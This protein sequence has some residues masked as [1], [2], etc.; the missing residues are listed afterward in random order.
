MTKKHADEDGI[1]IKITENG[2]YLVYGKP[3]LKQEFITPNEEGASWEYQDG[4]RFSTDGEEPIALCRCGH[5]K[6]APFCDESHV[7]CGFDGTETASLEPIAEGSKEYRGPNYTL[8]DNE[9]YCAF[10]RFCDAFGQVWN[11]VMDGRDE[12]D[13]LAVREAC[14]CPAGRLRIR[15]N[16]EEQEIEPKFEKTIGV[17][18]DPAAHCSGPLY[19]KGGIKIEG[20]DG[21]VYELRNRQTLCRC[22]KSSHKPFCNGA[23]ASVRYSDGIK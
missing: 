14:Y 21:R 22:G 17:L 3:I 15:K 16:G 2:P 18:E 1:Y 8:L 12:A 6:N 23:H 4:K 7:E 9:A 13:M 10:A 5:S 11:L 20:A 19:I